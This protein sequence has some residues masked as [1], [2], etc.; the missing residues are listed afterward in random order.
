MKRLPS[1][2]LAAAL[3][4]TSA[5]AVSIFHESFDGNDQNWSYT[6]TGGRSYDNTGWTEADTVKPGYKGVKL[7]ST[8][9][10]GTITSP[11]FALNNRSQPVSITIVAAAYQNTGGGKEGIALAVYDDSDASIFTDSVEELPQFSSTAKDE[12]PANATFTQT[13][14][15]PAA[16]L[17]VTGNVYLSIT[18]TYT[19]TGQ[20]RALIGDVL[21]EQNPPPL[22]APTDLALSGDAGTDSFTVTWTGV[23]GATGYD[24][25]CSPSGSASVN[26][27]SATISG[28]TPSTTYTVSVVALGNGTSSSDS[29]AA[30]LQVTTA[31]A[32]VN[33]PPVVRIFTSDITPT[34]NATV[35]ATVGE[36]VSVSVTADKG[37]LSV[38]INDNPGNTSL[39]ENSEAPGTYIFSWTPS[40][41]GEFSFTISSSFTPEGASE[42]L[43]G[44][45]T[46][47]VN[48][49]ALSTPEHISASA[50]G[51]TVSASWDSVTGAQGY[52]TTLYG[53]TAFTLDIGTNSP[54]TG[55]GYSLLKGSFTGDSGEP[56]DWTVSNGRISSD[57]AWFDENKSAIAIKPNSPNYFIAGPFASDI[58]SF[59]F[60]YRKASGTSNGHIHV[61]A[62]DSYGQETEIAA[63]TGLKN[64]DQPMLTNATY[65]VATNFVDDAFSAR[66]IK[67]TCTTSPVLIDDFEVHTLTVADTQDISAQTT[68]HTF[69]GL[70]S[71]TYYAVGVKATGSTPS[72]ESVASPEV[73][74]ELVRTAGN[75]PPTLNVSGATV[76]AGTAAIL[77]LNGHDDDGN[78]L[79]YTVSPTGLGTIAI[80]DQTG[81]ATFTY[82][83]NAVGTTTFT[84]TVSDGNGGSAT[85]EATVTATLGTPVVTATATDSTVVTLGWGAV[86]GAAGYRVSG[87]G[88]KIGVTGTTM[89][90]ET[91]DKFANIGSSSTRIDDNADT[92]MDHAGWTLVNAYRGDRGSNPNETGETMETACF[93]TG[94]YAGS[95]TSPTLDLSGNGGAFVVVF[96]AR[97]WGGD[98]SAKVAVVVNG[99][100]NQTQAVLSDSMATYAISCTGGTS[101]TIVQITG[102][103]PK[104]NRFFL[105][106]LK[107]VSGTATVTDLAIAAEQLSISGTTCT[108]MGLSPDATYTFTVTAYAT[109]AGDE[110]TTSA[111][112]AVSTPEAP[113]RTLILFR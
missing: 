113:D 83:P 88:T 58:L 84:F 19:K 4:A 38:E 5:H 92:Y 71:A 2:L 52:T 98:T 60:K 65:T 43:T 35:N 31:A 41:L 105:D 74:S 93:G 73:V 90:E 94:N 11:S 42:S 33:A 108:A 76:P 100:T 36:S 46:L 3:A 77:A 111:N 82:T 75:T 18:S 48:A 10:T 81:A 34:D 40:A 30:T 49:N 12:I 50:S 6:S 95:L 9:A 8:S 1:L 14:T 69:T 78:T 55:T 22:S 28:L 96:R 23:S 16:S 89:L 70:N 62:I 79:T 47:T 99:V 59:S 72:N 67:I 29:S 39:V 13:F 24:V 17:P 63:S 80:D 20:R 61:Y 15:I 68:T 104:D 66:S 103:K 64:M 112:V 101:G 57:D 53:D 109:V 45:A 21:V 32:A 86:T 54:T 87:S 7:G 110:V 26:G 37:D 56:V 107:I 27:T 102:A 97:R 85:A 25:A 44:S 51:Q 91:F 106:D